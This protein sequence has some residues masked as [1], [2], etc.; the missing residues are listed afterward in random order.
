M[1]WCDIVGA[2]NA[3]RWVK[4]INMVNFGKQKLVDYRANVSK[5][6]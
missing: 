5:P 3:N 2:G 6:W 1:V 4:N